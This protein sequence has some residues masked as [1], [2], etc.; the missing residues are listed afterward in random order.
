[1]V[2]NTLLR[3]GL[4]STSGRKLRVAAGD[5]TTGANAG[6]TT[7][8]AGTGRKLHAAAPAPA[9][10]DFRTPSVGSNT[11]AGRKLQDASV[12]GTTAGVSGRKLQDASVGGTTAGVSG[13]KLQDASV[14][15][16]T[17]GVSG[18]KLQ[19]ASVGGTTAGV[20]G[21]KLHDASVGGTTAGV[22]GRKLQDAS[23][24]GTTAGVSGRKLQD[25][26]VGGTTAGVSGRKLQDAENVGG[27]GVG[28]NIPNRRLHQA[29]LG[30]EGSTAASSTVNGGLPI[31]SPSSRTAMAPTNM[32]TGRKL[33]DAAVVG[34]E[35][36]G[37]NIPNRRLQQA[38]LGAEGSTAAS[39]TSNGGLPMVSPSSQTAMAP[40]TNM[41]SG[42]KL[43]DASVSDS[44]TVPGAGFVSG[45]N[46]L[47][48]AVC[49]T[50]S[51]ACT[52]IG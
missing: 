16:T 12:G 46:L 32:N 35:G 20:S 38:D 1:M 27:E 14:G 17:A 11:G 45:R 8:A 13:R 40:S 15:G 43:L 34:G 21:R 33:L 26:S 36:V 25:A 23:V 24:G 50:S 51:G 39:S 49:D 22:S 42:R 3:W 48:A 4:Q 47:D 44:S 29:D 9:V 2:A 30:A 28:R 19:D 52:A 18:R 41:N 6:D 31:V 7:G 5:A 37:F 10:T